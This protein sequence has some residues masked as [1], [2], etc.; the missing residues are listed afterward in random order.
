MKK[1]IW[2]GLLWGLSC[3]AQEKEPDFFNER[4]ILVGME[5]NVVLQPRH[6]LGENSY[7][8]PSDKREETGSL[9]NGNKGASSLQPIAQSLPQ[10][11]RSAWGGKEEA[12]ILRPLDGA[13]LQHS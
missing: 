2:I 8:T 4:T 9:G 5:E 6:S 3:G 12:S 1:K 7:K 11:A 10:H 13:Y